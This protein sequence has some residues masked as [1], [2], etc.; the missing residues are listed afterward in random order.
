MKI[1]LSISMDDSTVALI[2][3]NV[4]GGRFRNKSHAIEYAVNKLIWEADDDLV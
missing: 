4:R 1:K 2:E 3:E